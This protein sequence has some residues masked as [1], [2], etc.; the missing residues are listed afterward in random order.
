MPQLRAV[1]LPIPADKPIQMLTR[2]WDDAYS[3]A[4]SVL[5]TNPASSIQIIESV[6]ILRTVIPTLE[7]R[8]HLDGY[9]CVVCQKEFTVRLSTVC[10]DCRKKNTKG[11]E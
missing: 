11:A 8:K 7:D 3:W 10:R 9:A 5:A 4:E 2:S 1:L 6:E